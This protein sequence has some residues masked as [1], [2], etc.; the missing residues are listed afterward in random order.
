LP[1]IDRSIKIN[2]YDMNAKLLIDLSFLG[3]KYTGLTTYAKNLIPHL[4]GLDPLLLTSTPH[5]DART[6][7]VPVNLTQEQ[8]TKGNLRRLLWKQTQLPRLYRQCNASGIF[9]PIPEAPIYRDC[10]YVVTVHD[11]I[12]LRFPKFSPLTLYNRYY[13]PLVLQQAAQI[14]AVS[15]TTAN[16]IYN[17]LQIPLDKITVIPSGYDRA[18]FRPLDLPTRSYFLYI[19][20]YDPHK[21]LSRLIRAFARVPS[22]YQLWLVGQFDPRFTPR[23]QQQAEELGVS[24]RI[25]F[26]NYVPYEELPILLNQAL[27]LVYPSLWEGFGLP[28]LEAI[29][30]GTP[31]ITS[32][33]SSLPE[34][35]GN[36]AILV[37]PYNIAEISEAMRQ[38]GNSEALRSRLRDLGLQRASLL[39]WEKTGEATI[40]VLQRFL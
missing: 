11:L 6:Y 29:A 20:R 23:L 9:S 38:I 18:N 30:C 12:P 15:E 24:S 35:V 1:R 2:F 7:P 36:A 25:Q 4:Q 31:V 37:D 14:I 39:S 27:A 16:D 28:V 32:N 5:D 33:L 10:R 21:N 34:V 19:G 17:F 22:D 40:E 8:G 3:T 13:L 26:L